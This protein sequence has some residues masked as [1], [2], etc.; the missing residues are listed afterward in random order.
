MKFVVEINCDNSAFDK[1]LLQETT[2]IIETVANTLDTE[3]FYGQ[4]DMKL[5]DSNGNVVGEAR[6]VAD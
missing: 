6:F 5:W 2:S 4:N 3:F 1:R